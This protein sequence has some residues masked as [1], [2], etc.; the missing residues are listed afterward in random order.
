MIA[1]LVAL[2]GIA[3]RSPSPRTSGPL[4]VTSLPK[5]PASW[6]AHGGWLVVGWWV[7]VGGWWLVKARIQRQELFLTGNARSLARRWN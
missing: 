7:V 1:P 6:T 5:G 4:A 3:V 2:P